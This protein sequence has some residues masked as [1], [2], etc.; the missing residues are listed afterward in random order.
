MIDKIFPLFNAA[1][2]ASS[3]IISPLALLERTA[4]SGKCFKVSLLII[5]LVSFVAG[6]LIEKKSDTESKLFKE[7][8]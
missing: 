2:I 1:T 5:C 7:L 6:Q 4:P 3:S 8:W